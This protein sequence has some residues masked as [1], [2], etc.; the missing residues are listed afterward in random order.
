[1]RHLTIGACLLLAW[2][3]LTST[4]QSAEPDEGSDV[5][6][7]LISAGESPRN[8]IRF[9][10]KSGQTESMIMTMKMS[11]KMTID[12]TTFPSPASPTQKFTLK[13]SIKDVASNGDVNYEFE[14]A[15]IELIDDPKNPSPLAPIMMNM[16]KPMIGSKGSAVVSNRGLTKK[17]EFKFNDGMPPQLKTMLDGM[18]DSVG[19]I[20]SPVP[21]EPIGLG[22]KWKVVQTMTTNGMTLKQISTHELTKRSAD[23]F[24]IASKI[25]QEA[26]PQEV[27]SPL[28]P[29][30]A[31]MNLESLSTDGKGTAGFRFA[32]IM[33]ANADSSV[34]SNAA[35]TINANGKDQHLKI[36]TKIEVHFDSPK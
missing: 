20:S 7:E 32:S 34:L 16:L 23:G 36:E 3:F 29:P 11:Q 28:L 18:M 27:K 19:K 17:S 15:N 21:E 4:I 6:V 22:G 13:M 14:F 8:E 25:S 35:M 31:K 30:E 1:M 26:D 33:P 5:V 9:Q 24:E 2:G 10:P 12:G